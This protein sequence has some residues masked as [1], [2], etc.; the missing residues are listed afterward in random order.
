MKEKILLKLFA[1][2]KNICFTI[3]V[4][5]NFV[6]TCMMGCKNDFQGHI[7]K[8]LVLINQR[9]SFCTFQT[10]YI[11]WN[12]LCW[13]Y[14]WQRHSSFFSDKVFQIS[15]LMVTFMILKKCAFGKPKSMPILSKSFQYYLQRW[16][17]LLLLYFFWIKL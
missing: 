4:K 10:H 2:R 7:L 5:K 8:L 6:L 9:C 17:A 14:W 1:R 12:M 3:D 11:F 16:D 13:W 15:W